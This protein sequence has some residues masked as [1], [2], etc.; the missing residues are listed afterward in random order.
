MR[1]RFNLDL[2][3][4]TRDKLADALN[5]LNVKSEMMERGCLEEKINDTWYTRSLGVIQIANSSVKWINILKKDRGQ[6]NPPKWWVVMGVPDE[7]LGLDF[8]NIKIRSVRKKRFPLF[9][10]V[11]DVVW[12]GEDG[13]TGL[14]E[15]LSRDITSKTL[16]MRIGN[17]EIA[18]QSDR[19]QGWTLTVDR[20]F[21]PTLE[22]WRTVERITDHILS[23][24]QK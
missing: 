21:S 23:S 20:R 24:I 7:R 11:I 12:V 15:K 19:F 4:K 10:K 13:D 3:D 2:R 1:E 6:H 8:Q 17:L 22:D 5:S 9:G 14:L 16:P 18:S